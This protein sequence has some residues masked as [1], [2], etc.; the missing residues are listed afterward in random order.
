MEFTLEILRSMSIVMVFGGAVLCLVMAVKNTLDWIMLTRIYR[1]IAKDGKNQSVSY[2]S[3]PS[4]NT[5]D[6]L[7]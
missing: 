4:S 5:D 2:V 7:F 3:P 1:T 6:D